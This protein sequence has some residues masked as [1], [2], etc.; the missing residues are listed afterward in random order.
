M[1]GALLQDVSNSFSASLLR[2]LEDAARERDVAIVAAS[3][4]EEPERERALVESL[5]RRRVDGLLLMPATTRQDYL[6]D[7]LR[8]GLPVVFVDRRP[9]GVDAD[10]VTIDNE[11]GSRMAA[12]HLL[13]HGH[14]RI[15]M[16]ADLE[17]I[18]TAAAR[19]AGFE[20]GLAEG[21]VVMDPRVSDMSTRSPED[22]LAA[23]PRMFA[24]PDPPTAIFAARN[25]LAI[26]AIR[27]LHRRGLAGRVALVGFD[28]FPLADILDPPLTVIRQNV[29]AIGLQVTRRL[30]AAH[31]RRRLGAPAR[32]PRARAGREGIGRDPTGRTCRSEDQ[33]RLTAPP[34]QWTHRNRTGD[35]FALLRDRVFAGSMTTAQ[36]CVTPPPA[37][38][39]L[40]RPRARRR[41]RAQPHRAAVHGPALRGLGGPHGGHRARGRAGGA[42]VPA[43]RRGARHHAARLRR[44]RGAAPDA[45]RQTPT[46]PVLFLTAKDAVEDRVAGLTA[47]GDDYVTKPFSLEEVVARLRGLMR[48]TAV[49]ADDVRPRCSSSA[50][51]R[52]TRTATR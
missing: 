26:G 19:R 34:A 2:S 50:T 5:V 22:A 12:A 44:A 6:A 17:G 8:S 29:G 3:L 27:A 46:C 45:R 4:D 23:V 51:S 48:R 11:L 25:S 41:R 30:F 52:W 36:S 43:R 37:P 49:V 42:R 20:L 13:A 39:R 15:A 32:G 7:D 10:S 40:A 35:T 24:V 47:G 14:R 21:G 18:Q 9:N 28:D 1:V 31:R 33:P 16:L 38:R